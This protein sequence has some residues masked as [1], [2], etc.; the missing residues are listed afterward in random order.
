MDIHVSVNNS[1]YAQQHNLDHQTADL[2]SMRQNLFVFVYRLHVY[3][4]SPIAD[5]YR[6]PFIIILV[7]VVWSIF[8]YWFN[9][10]Q[11]STVCS[12]NNTIRKT[13]N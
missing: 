6:V 13:A 9:W 2:T 8:R 3:P 5:L 10:T 11:I 7:V 1:N 4:V 12:I